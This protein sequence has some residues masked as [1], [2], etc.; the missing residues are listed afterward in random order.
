[1]VKVSVIIPVCN[2]EKYLRECLDSLFAQTLKEVEIICVDDGSTD[3]SYEILEEYGVKILRQP[4]QGAGVA[5]NNGMRMAVGEYLVF[6]DA[7]DVFA[8]DMLG[9]MYS[10]GE[11]DD[12][13]VV[14]CRH[15]IYE[16]DKG[17][18][19]DP[20]GVPFP[21][22]NASVEYPF[23][24]ES[25][26]PIQA[27]APAP[28]NKMFK[29]EMVRR[30]KLE[31]QSL[32]SSNDIFFTTTAKLCAR[33]V[34]V[35][36]EELVYYR[37][38]HGGNIQAKLY[39]DPSCIV[40]A[41]SAI[42]KFICSRGWQSE[43]EEKFLEFVIP[44][45]MH[46][47]NI[48]KDD[49]VPLKSFYEALAKSDLIEFVRR[50]DTKVNMQAARQLYLFKYLNT[51]SALSCLADASRPKV[52]ILLPVFNQERYID[53]A[54]LSATSQTMREIEIICLD[55][56]SN[57]SSC[58]LM[59]EWAQRDERI[60]VYSH[61]RNE[62]LL[63]AR[64]TLIAA[65]RGDYI[66]NLDP[67]DTL[68]ADA[69]EK[70]YKLAKCKNADIVQGRFSIDNVN[71]L[72][73]SRLAWAVK[74]N[75]FSDN[76][77]IVGARILAEAF[78]HGKIG[79]NA[80]GKLILRPLAVKAYAELPD[81]RLTMAEDVL[82]SFPLFGYAKRC[83]LTSEIFY[84]YTYGT[85][86]SGKDSLTLEEYKK[87]CE[88][89]LIVPIIK[90][91]LSTNPARFNRSMDCLA[92]VKERM[93]NSGYGRAIN[94]LTNDRDR[95]A[96][97][98]Y[99]AGLMGEVEFIKFLAK[100]YFYQRDEII[101]LLDRVGFVQ[102]ITPKKIK[103]IGFVYFHLSIGGVQRVMILLAPIFQ[104]LGYEVC[105]ILEKEIGEGD[106]ELPPGVSL[107]L[108][109]ESSKCGPSSI[110]NRID[111]FKEV[112]ESEQVDLIYYHPY[113]SKIMQWD[114]LMTKFVCKVPFIL[115]FHNSISCCLAHD[116]QTPEFSYQAAKMRMCD[117]VIALSRI[118]EL[119]FQSQGVN[120]R[121]IPNP[122]D[123]A[124]VKALDQKRMLSSGTKNILWCA[125]VSWEKHPID[126]IRIFS[127]VHRRLPEARLLVVGGGDVAIAKQLAS[128]AKDQGCEESV[129]F[130][131]N[132]PSA[133]PYYE[134]ADAFLM[135]SEFEGFPMTLLEAGCY[136]LP[137]VMYSL[138][139]LEAVRGN[140]G[141]VQV[142]SGGVKDAASALI[143]I[144]TDECRCTAMSTANRSFT[145][146]FVEYNQSAAWKEIL[147]PLVDGAV[148]K[149]SASAASIADVRLLLE[150]IGQNYIGGFRA[151]TAH[152]KELEQSESYRLGLV[153]TCPIRKL[154]HFVK[155]I[156][157]NMVRK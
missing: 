124:L 78:V 112:I 122:V 54:L 111:A 64:K 48:L 114:L 41:L 118:D 157:R 88:E 53:A 128:V 101:N 97:L 95:G 105:F 100:R 155:G 40:S 18:K 89:V 147:S 143:D 91:L 57:D 66:V 33:K 65:S 123:P 45:L 28:W 62:G 26:L 13:D 63:Q 47:V 75:A 96:G 85:G 70:A 146:Q 43:L 140:E 130:I 141:I 138:P 16:C 129:E 93:Y 49:P 68:P 117:T 80:W 50:P 133:Y 154:Y 51:Q 106:F 98:H 21:E 34:A 142:H 82:A 110:N 22:I 35:V 116:V 25:A 61:S 46:T 149:G 103:K 59:L 37:V 125:R 94:F 12:A 153:L 109:P 135:T 119:Y 127:A 3:A 32:S 152:I 60:K 137:T 131:G 102:P 10:K 27:Y 7:D 9:K 39:G 81:V 73:P 148:A 84:N 71:N 23:R 121:Y 144:L 76:R 58:Q 145:R 11:S 69:C 14:C 36:D 107:K 136:G 115:H 156:R 139:Y 8:P 151:K 55:D 52:S 77:M 120:A 15:L 79:T 99:L 6:L 44:N 87:Q 134:K 24:N 31:Y 17:I 67:D 108:I 132:Q 74:I 5:R 92:C 38:G 104:K 83:Y 150:A 90:K 42:W 113:S 56:G 1:M 30:E 4:N 86:I 126:A 72:P 19:R 20:V 29:A 2:A